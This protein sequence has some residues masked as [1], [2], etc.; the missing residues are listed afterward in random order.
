M[1]KPHSGNRK[2]QKRE[3]KE[4][5]LIVCGSECSEPYYIS[6]LLEHHAI[7]SA[8]VEMQKFAVTPEVVV[9]KA[10]AISKDE[11]KNGENF[12]E[13][14]CVFDRDDFAHFE[15][16]KL[17]ASKLGYTCI[18]STPSFEY[19][20]LTHF[21]Q[22]TAPYAAVGAKTVGDLCL[23]DLKKELK[24]YTKNDRQIYTKLYDRLPAAIAFAKRRFN[25]S[26]EDGD[27]NPSTNFYLLVE[28][29]LRL[30]NIEI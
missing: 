26:K 6:N 16:A 14:Y 27:Y 24:T 9:N 19:W 25:A 5:I 13:V 8:H 21:K 7:N 15:K 20:L 12:D 18:E 22:T 29:L 10:K 17:T 30:G 11:K 28:R 3:Q 1:R 2:Q 4:R 23:H